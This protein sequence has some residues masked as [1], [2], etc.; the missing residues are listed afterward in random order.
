MDEAGDSPLLAVVADGNASH[1]QNFDEEAEEE[2]S[3]AKAPRTILSGG[4]EHPSPM[5]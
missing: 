2:K 3:L 4:A 5:M 1:E